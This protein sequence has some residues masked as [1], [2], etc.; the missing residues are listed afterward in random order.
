M[1]EEYRR[2]IA[3][4]NQQNQALGKHI[5]QLETLFTETEEV[6]SPKARIL[7]LEEQNQGYFE[8]LQ[9]AEKQRD[10]SQQMVQ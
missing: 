4:K 8:Q 1:N 2:E 5:L 6:E 10:Y 3:R 9:E 7:N